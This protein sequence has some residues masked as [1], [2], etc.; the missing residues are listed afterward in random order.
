MT[1]PIPTPAPM[2]AA[3]LE[4]LRGSVKKWEGIVA[5]TVVDEGPTNCP[6]CRMFYRKDTDGERAP[7]AGCPV[8]AYTGQP[9]CDGT[10]YGTYAEH[11][12]EA[13]GHFRHKC[14]APD[15]DEGRRLAQAE[16]DFLK[17]LLPEGTPD[18]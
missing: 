4:A 9:G 6:L 2:D 15:C 12:Y 14:H 11:E 7:C 10:P 3:T 18:V 13:H 1:D 8:S 17:S 16:V 5:G